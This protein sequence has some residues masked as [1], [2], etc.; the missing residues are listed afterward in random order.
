MYF[1][2]Y[3]LAKEIDGIGQSD[4][5]IDYKINRQ[6]LIEQELSF[7]FIRINS[8]EEGFDI[9]RTVNEIFRRIKQL[10][11]RTLIN[12]ISTKTLGLECKLDNIVKSNAIKFIV[13]KILPDYK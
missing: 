10:S 4:R 7:K 1:Y 11:K 3:N 6:K 5:N 2:D 8:D 12:K 9:F 13:K